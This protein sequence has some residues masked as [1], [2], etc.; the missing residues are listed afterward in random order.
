MPDGGAAP[1][2]YPARPTISVDGTARPELAEGL[3]EMLVEETAD[4]LYRCELTVGN[5]GPAQGAMDYLYFDR[6]LLDF[7][8]PLKI[9]AGAGAGSGVIFDG[10]ISA[11]E[12][13]YGAGRPPELL[14]LAEDRLQDLRMTRRTRTFENL[15]DDALINQIASAHSL[16]PQVDVNGAQ[17]T[18]IAQLNQSDLAFLRDLA[19]GLDA[20]VWVEGRTLHVQARAR[21]QAGAFALT[22][23]HGLFEFSVT[24]DLAGQV[25]GFTV[26]GWDVQAKQGISHRAAASAISGELGSATGG[27][28][29]LDQA[30]GTRDQQMVHALPVTQAEAQALAEA[31]YRRVARRFVVGSGIAEGDARIRVGA[32]LELRDLGPLFSGKYQVV[33]A[34]HTFDGA[35]GFRSEFTA[36]RPGIGS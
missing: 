29:I 19:R 3:S 26:S 1:A 2:V 27:S 20:E 12:G 6:Q 13:R 32:E 35:L 21:R 25:S 18:V 9:E 24:A 14:V 23:Q 4:G 10:R 30:F 28:S 8:K 16:T 34:A 5:Y 11:L 33:R 15:T 17:H 22:Y 7:G 31:H 36:E